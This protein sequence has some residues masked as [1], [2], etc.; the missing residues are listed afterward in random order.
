M[1]ILIFQ[2][3]LAL[4]SE[5]CGAGDIE[6]GGDNP[7]GKSRKIIWIGWRYSLQQ[8]KNSLDF[9]NSSS[10][11]CGWY[12]DSILCWPPTMPGQVLSFL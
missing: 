4:P 8:Q 12:N 5:E 3:M 11:M 10:G 2:K 9:L 7:L 1:L 6:R